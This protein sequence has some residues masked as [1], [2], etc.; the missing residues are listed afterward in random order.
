VGI[1]AR[2]LNPTDIDPAVITRIAEMAERI[3]GV[4]SANAWTK[5]PGR[6]R[7]YIELRRRNNSGWADGVGRRIY[8]D[9]KGKVN[10]DDE[11]ANAPTKKWHVDNETVS[12]V[13][14]LGAILRGEE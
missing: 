5:A 9:A 8:L 11:Y 1:A 4:M 10:L 6:E 3:N 14:A 7:I 12:K 13:R 2:I